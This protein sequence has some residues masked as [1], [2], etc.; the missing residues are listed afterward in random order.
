VNLGRYSKFI[1]A[2]VGA[3]V[4]IL[5]RHFGVESDIVFDVVA[6][7]TALGVYQVPNKP[8]PPA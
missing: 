7:A 4:L 8:M 2:S 3:L 5:T 6:V 1:V